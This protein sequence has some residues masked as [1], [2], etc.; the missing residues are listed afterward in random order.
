L[1]GGRET[2]GSTARIIRLALSVQFGLTSPF[3]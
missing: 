1:T 2:L 3:R